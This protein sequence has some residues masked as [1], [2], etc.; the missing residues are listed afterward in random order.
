MPLNAEEAFAV[1]EAAAIL[2]RG[3]LV[4]FPIETVSHWAVY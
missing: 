4:A 3:G 1:R 2:R